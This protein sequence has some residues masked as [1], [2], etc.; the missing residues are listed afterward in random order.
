MSHDDR[1]ATPPLHPIRDGLGFLAAAAG[2][3][4]R[5]FGPRPHRPV[6]SAADPATDGEPVDIHPEDPAAKI[7]PFSP[8]D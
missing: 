4:A 1:D 5:T 7:A 6:S 3:L 8:K 2:A